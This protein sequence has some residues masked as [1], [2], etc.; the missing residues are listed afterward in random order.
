[1]RFGQRIRDLRHEKHLSQR[2]VAAHVGIDFTY[3]SKI[4]L[5][6]LAPPSETVI[7]R[8][9]VVLGA[10]VNELINLAGKVPSDLKGMLRD[11]PHAVALLQVLRTKRLP[12]VTYCELIAI[13]RKA[14]AE[15]E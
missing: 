12:A 6:A 1:M 8:L 14:Q 9:A 13:A 10:D 11:N 2:A 4:E 15:R 7:T 3:L 5:G